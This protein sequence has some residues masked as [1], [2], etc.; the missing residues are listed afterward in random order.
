MDNVAE[1]IGIKGGRWEERTD[2]VQQVLRTICLSCKLSNFHPSFTYMLSVSQTA[3]PFF[4]LLRLGQQ[5][6]LFSSHTYFT[7]ST[8]F[9]LLSAP[10]L[11]LSLT[12]RISLHLQLKE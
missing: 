2:W 6:I 4:T 10:L 12:L 11:L 7:V 8:P 5:L 3:R 9:L 1:E